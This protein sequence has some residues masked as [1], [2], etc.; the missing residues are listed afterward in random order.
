MQHRHHKH[1]RRPG[2]IE[3]PS[4]LRVLQDL[5]GTARVLLDRGRPIVSSQN[6][7][8]VRDG[9]RVDVDVDDPRARCHLLRDLMYVSAGVYARPE[10]EKLPDPTST[11]SVIQKPYSRAW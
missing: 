2:E 5:F 7:P 6:L 10:V 3:Q 4:N 8:A 11:R 1:R 9:H